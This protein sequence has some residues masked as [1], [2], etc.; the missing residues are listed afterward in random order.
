MATKDKEV[1]AHQI[2]KQLGSCSTTLN[3]DSSVDQTSGDGWEVIWNLFPY[4]VNRS[5]IDLA[6]WSREELTTFIRG[7][8]FQHERRP[9]STTTG[10]LE[11]TTVDILSTRRL[12]DAELNNWGSDIP[13]L[14]QDLPGF[15]DSTVDLMEVV[16]G[17]RITYVSNS[18]M[19][20]GLVGAVYVT[21]GASTFGSGNPIATDKLHWTRV[22]WVNGSGPSEF[23]TLGSTNLVTQATTMKED[24]LVWIE[25][26]R[27]SYVIQD[28][29]DI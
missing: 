13:T 26:L 10:V 8:D 1:K 20:V 14:S 5:Y 17:E 23:L 25:R 15:A 12:T 21:L 11:V 29:A 9:R 16:Y 7:V 6:G 18:T 27:R 3:F 28:Q 19:A 22:V 2:Y 4:L 24:D